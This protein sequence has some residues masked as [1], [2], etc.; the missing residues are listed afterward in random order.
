[1]GNNKEYIAYSGS[2]T[3]PPCTEGVTFIIFREFQQ[4]NKAQWDAFANSLPNVSFSYTSATGNYRS[5]NALNSRTIYQKYGVVKG[6][7]LIALAGLLTSYL[8]MTI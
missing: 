5:V 7:Y 2:F 8:L 3:T 6:G 4:M 1:M